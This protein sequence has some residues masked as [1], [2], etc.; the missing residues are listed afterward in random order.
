MEVSGYE[1]C[2]CVE[3]YLLAVWNIDNSYSCFNEPSKYLMKVAVFDMFRNKSFKKKSR[4]V[5]R[6]DFTSI[7]QRACIEIAMFQ[8]IFR[9]CWRKEDQR[10]AKEN[11]FAWGQ[12][13]NHFRTTRMVM[14][15]FRLFEILRIFHFNGRTTISSN[16]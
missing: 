6:L 13:D 2:F 3:S 11:S 1:H 4:R 10:R 5:L 7:M 14:M 12:R 8:V 9:L 16:I 15:R